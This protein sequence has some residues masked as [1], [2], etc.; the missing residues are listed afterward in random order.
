M[1]LFDNA[2][3]VIHLNLP[4]A[5]IVYYPNF[6]NS[7]SASKL[8]DQLLNG[9]N[10]KQDT[11]TVY[12]KRYLQPRL[13]YL[14][15]NND[16]PYSYSNILMYPEVYPEYLLKVKQQIDKLEQMDFTTCLVNRYRNGTDSNGWHAD[17]EEELGKQP[18]IASLSLGATR[19]FHLKHKTKT[20]RKAKIALTHGSLLV[21]KGTTQEFWLHQVPKTKKK[22][23]ERINLTFRVI[24]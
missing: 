24:K 19:W 9:V 6:M 22:V 17:N 4:E 3:D 18:V 14:F 15:G 2:E 12:G 10:W 1:L 7:Q 5:E 21:M 16:K 13:T 11:I 23:A 20:E 8:F